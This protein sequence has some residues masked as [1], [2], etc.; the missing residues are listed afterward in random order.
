M[1]PRLLGD[2]ERRPNG[3]MVAPLRLRQ[4]LLGFLPVEGE[5]LG[6]APIQDLPPQ[7]PA[8]RFEAG[9]IQAAMLLPRRARDE[10]LLHR[11]EAD[12]HLRGVNPMARIDGV[13]SATVAGEFRVP[14]SSRFFE[15][16]HGLSP[17]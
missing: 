16:P 1:P 3:E 11:V 7:L 14:S 8:D 5:R 6:A 12:A 13:P 15:A 2:V 9:G 17:V 10:G 4:A